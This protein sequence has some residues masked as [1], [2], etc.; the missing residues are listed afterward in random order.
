[1]HIR[2]MAVKIDFDTYPAAVACLGPGF[3]SIPYP[4]VDGAYVV[5]NAPD[6]RRLIPNVRSRGHSDMEARSQSALRYYNFWVPAELF[7]EEYTWVSKEKKGKFSECWKVA[8][9]RTGLN[10]DRRGRVVV[11]GD[12][13]EEVNDGED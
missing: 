8:E 11:E 1:M 4:Q 13:L 3:A 6:S 10:R 9:A 12:D 2:T 5:I 7:K